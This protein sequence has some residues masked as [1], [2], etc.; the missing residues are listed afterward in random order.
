MSRE[1][2][3][4]AAS[5]VAVVAAV[6]AGLYVAGSPGEE[7]LR[8]LDD[9]RV[10]D[11]RSVSRVIT[12]YWNSNEFLPETLEV[13]VDGSHFSV[14]PIDPVSERV[15]GYE[16]HGEREYSLCAEFDR[17]SR[18][19]DSGDFWDHGAGRTCFRLTAFSDKSR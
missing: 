2:I 9:Q 6:V 7:R 4:L 12:R 3:A 10:N 5:I 18:D 11:L 17:E 16:I 8:K 13:L 1:R 14:L 15:Y 19:R